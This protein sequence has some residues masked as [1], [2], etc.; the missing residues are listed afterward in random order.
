MHVLWVLLSTC[1]L[2]TTPCDSCAA[3]EVKYTH[4]CAHAVLS[5]AAGPHRITG[6]IFSAL[7][8]F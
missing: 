5:L 3:Y 1:M 4:C 6:Y 7:R 8:C 2:C